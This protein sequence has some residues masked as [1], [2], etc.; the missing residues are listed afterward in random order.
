[1]AT[2]PDSKKINRESLNQSLSDRYISGQSAGGAY[3]PVQK[4]VKTVGSNEISLGGST[5]DTNYTVTKGFK[6]KQGTQQTEFKDAVDGQR[7]LQQSIYLKGFNNK[8][9]TNGSFGR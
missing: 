1:M 7:S 6:I 4:N 9:Y 5:F 8:K 3:Q 2:S